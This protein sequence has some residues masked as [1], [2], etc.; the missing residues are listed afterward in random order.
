MTSD[1]LVDRLL[2]FQEWLTEQLPLVQRG[3]VLEK[4]QQEVLAPLLRDEEE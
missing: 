4:F 1:K 3:K 2:K